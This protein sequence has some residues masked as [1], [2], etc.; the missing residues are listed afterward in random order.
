MPISYLSKTF[1]ADPT[2]LPFSLDLM[3]KVLSVKQ[4]KFDEGARAIQGGINQLASTD[5]IKNQ[6]KAYLNENVNKLVGELNSYGGVDLSDSNVSNYLQSA[7]NNIYNDEKIVNAISG[8]KSIR[9]LQ[10]GYQQYKTDPKLNK[11]YSQSNE[12]NDNQ[13]VN[14]YLSEDQVGSV[15]HGASNPTPYVPY[16]DN[17]IKNIQGVK[18]NL[19]QSLTPNGDL[20]YLNEKHE[21]ITPERIVQMAKDLSTA[22]EVGQIDRDGLYQFR[23]IQP[24]ALLNKAVDLHTS[25]LENA[26]GTLNRYKSQALQA[27]NDPE[28]KQN[29]KY[30]IDQQQ[31][32]VDALTAVTNTDFIKKYQQDPAAFSKGV[33]ADEL[34]RGLG[35]RFAYQKTERSV[36]PNYATMFNV[37][38]EQAERFHNDNMA[39]DYYKA[40]AKKDKNGKIIPSLE[41]TSFTT[42]PVNT[43]NPDDIPTGEQAL[44]LRN[45]NLI[46]ENTKDLSTFLSG[47]ANSE[48]AL[49]QV[50]QS[51]QSAS[52][53][54]VRLRNQ[55]LIETVN[56][57]PGFQFGD[58][59]VAP[60]TTKYKELV[61]KGIPE[62]NLK[63]YY[64]MYKGYQQLATGV[65]NGVKDFPKGF[66]GVVQRMELRNGAINAN[67]IKKQ[68]VNKALSQQ[69]GITESDTEF[70]DKYREI[71]KSGPTYTTDVVSGGTAM[72]FG[73]PFSNKSLGKE[74][75]E[76]DK[77]F[78]RN[79]RDRYIK[80]NEKLNST[81][82]E[83]DK[84]L[85]FDQIEKRQQYPNAILGESNLGKLP[86]EDARTLAASIINQRGG[87]SD[88]GTVNPGLTFSNKDIEPITAG[89]SADGRYL[90]K[91]RAKEGSDKDF[92][93]YTVELSPNNVKEFGFEESPYQAITEETN[94]IGASSPKLISGPQNKLRAKIVTYRVNPDSDTDFTTRAYIVDDKG[95]KITDLP[96]TT[97]DRADKSYAAAI[98]LLGTAETSGMTREQFINFSIQNRNK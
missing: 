82:Y 94:L 1:T 10:A 89:K 15:Y 48:P 2:T 12:W 62:S 29:Y 79:N 33:Y 66:E 53:I 83:A 92:K 71:V 47:L 6:D 81:G 7:G 93:T 84:K 68:E 24:S 74:Y 26:V 30:L 69:Y 91:F 73:V 35:S 95:A 42:E 77:T 41:T 14:A 61:Q 60:N 90:Y 55:D 80:L 57:I 43:Q 96:N 25:K 19:T 23:N 17:L 9:N 72:G 11:L 20:I 63:I 98:A 8:T 39:I 16:K 65:E 54:T 5:I 78:L 59:N 70:I 76:E 86:L 49:R 75:S 97:Q 40:G 21:E 44:N 58:L 31:K 38:M 13:P 45:T 27:T 85:Y 3:A 28:A 36:T 88:K 52:G 32:E 34:Y 46:N 37:K 64:D 18:A 22:D 51:Q 50:M 67:T 4:S 87:T 56:N